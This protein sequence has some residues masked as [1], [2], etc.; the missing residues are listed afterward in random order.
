[1]IDCSFGADEIIES[2]QWYADHAMVNTNCDGLPPTIS[3]NFNPNTFVHVN[4]NANQFSIPNVKSFQTVVF[5]ASD[6]CGATS[7]CTRTVVIVDNAGPVIEGEPYLTIRECDDLVQS[8]YDAWIQD[9]LYKMS[10]TDACG[11]ATWSHTPESPNQE[12]WINGYALS[13]IHI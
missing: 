2:F 12:T 9:N 1:M 3:D 10:I 11:G 6:P 4:C 5:T 8:E 7:S 13:L